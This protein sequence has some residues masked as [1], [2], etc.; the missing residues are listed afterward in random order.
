MLCHH[1][2]SPNSHENKFL[3]V[4]Y[5]GGLIGFQPARS[6]A[7]P[8]ARP[9]VGLIG[10]SCY[11][12]GVVGNRLMLSIPLVGQPAPLTGAKRPNGRAG[13]LQLH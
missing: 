9:P 1:Q 2:I 3:L 11:E 12:G 6:P 7:M 5:L 8:D 4:T 13:S 10:W